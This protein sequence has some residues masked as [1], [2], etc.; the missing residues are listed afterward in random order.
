MRSSSTE[1]QSCALW[2][3]STHL[4]DR[5]CEN[6][7]DTQVTG[8]GMVHELPQDLENGLLHAPYRVHSG[9]VPHFQI[10]NNIRDIHRDK[11]TPNT[12]AA[13]IP[14]PLVTQTNRTRPFRMEAA[15]RDSSPFILRVRRWQRGCYISP[16]LQPQQAPWEEALV[17]GNGALLPVSFFVSERCYCLTAPL[18]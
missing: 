13:D 3:S 1:P 17:P 4:E 15:L 12:T 8:S 5:T 11:S 2:L 9:V 10:M 7:K 18:Q 16:D 14:G 6:V